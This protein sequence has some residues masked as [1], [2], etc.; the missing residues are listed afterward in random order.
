MANMSFIDEFLFN[1]PNELFI[2]WFFSERC[3]D[4][5][6]EDLICS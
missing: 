2:Y 1:C 4:L 5:R 3:G 6:F